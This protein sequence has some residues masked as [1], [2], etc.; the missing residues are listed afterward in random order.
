LFLKDAS[1]QQWVAT[2]KSMAFY[3]SVIPEP[4]TW[5]MSVLSGLGMA[6]V[7]ARRRRLLSR[8]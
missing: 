3:F 5:V 4:S 1:T 2:N 8:Q 7:V 6:G